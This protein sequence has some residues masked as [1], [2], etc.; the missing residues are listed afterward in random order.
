[1][2]FS[3]MSDIFYNNLFFKWITPDVSGSFGGGD[4]PVNYQNKTFS[5]P[6]VFKKKFRQR[7]ESQ[8]SF[9]LG[10]MMKP[11]LRVVGAYLCKHGYTWSISYEPYH[12][13]NIRHRYRG[14]V[15]RVV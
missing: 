11:R 4:K 3:E 8:P 9:F 5:Q 13:R 6:A 2:N 12:L 1:M 15:R 7:S 14:V 10:E